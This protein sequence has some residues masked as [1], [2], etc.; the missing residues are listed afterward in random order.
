MNATARAAIQPELQYSPSCNTARAAIQPEPL[1]SRELRQC[2]NFTANRECINIHCSRIV[3]RRLLRTHASNIKA[4]P[5]PRLVA[6]LKVFME[7]RRA[8]CCPIRR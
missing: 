3:K 8:S 2:G 5:L 4:S 1:R 6:M 7:C